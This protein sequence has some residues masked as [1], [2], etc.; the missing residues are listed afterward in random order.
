MKNQ[1]MVVALACLLLTV[2][3][4]CQPPREPVEGA[5]GIGDVY[6][7]ELGN[8]GYDVQKYTIV[9]DI[10]PETNTVK[11]KTVISAKATQRLKTLNL[12][13]QGLTVDSVIVNRATAEFS[14][15]GA[16]MTVTPPEPLPSE[17]DFTVEVSYHGRPTP[18]KSQ[19]AS[20]EVGWFHNEDNTI[21]VLSEPDGAS[22]WYPNNN[23]PRDKATYHLEIKVPNPWV[24][25]ATG[26]LTRTIPAGEHTLY[27]VD[28]DDPAASYLVSLNIDK[29]TLAEMDGPDGIRIRNYF[30]PDYPES[31]K[32]NF[33]KLPQMMEYLISIYG[34]YPFD[35]YGVVIASPH[36]DA[37]QWIGALEAQSLSIH[38]PGHFMATE[39]VIVHEAA[40]Q[41]FG[42]LV[43]LENWKDIWLK[44][45]MATYAQWLWMTRDKD[46]ETLTKVMKAQMVGYYPSRPVGDPSAAL[47]Y[48]EEVYRG[49]ALVFHALR[50]KVGEEA[51][52][53]ILRAYLD[54]Y[55]NSHAGTDEFIAL[56]E[57]ISG[58]D[59][60]EFFDSWLF[61]N[62]L[63]EMPE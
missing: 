54:R 12:D 18:V 51:F 8:G 44:E 13:F 27:I 6:Y 35:E 46:L 63:P 30:P 57:E 43:S 33:E 62:K 61:D 39:E 25:A 15:E 29:Y 17:R 7:A 26:T 58:Q 37:C 41:W 55:R 22:T 16:E 9:L 49:G 40:H 48:R 11:G 24:V 47:L 2:T 23:H 21:N 52:F 1:G 36:T 3:F 56:A 32:S 34:P 5:D 20:G 42:N 38:C 59:L 19:A 4:A 14:Q 31:R 10:D 53:N 60:K 28:M 45:G 50:L